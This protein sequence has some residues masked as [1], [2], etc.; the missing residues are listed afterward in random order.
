MSID[1]ALAKFFF[2]CNISFS[3]VESNLFEE[4]IKLLNPE[5]KI[6]S[7]KKLSNQLLD[8]VHNEI[9]YKTVKEHETVGV[10]LI[11][12]W[13]NSAANTKLIIC[14]IYTVMDNNMYLNSWD[15]TGERETGDLLIK[16]VDEAMKI[17]KS[18][19]TCVV[20]ERSLLSGSR[21]F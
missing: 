14:K 21:V 2:G 13:K 6:P 20:A 15:L 9:I 19:F 12:G 11:D 17:A 8:K 7:R 4:F 16:I 5:Y 10:L 1:L 18:K 3:V